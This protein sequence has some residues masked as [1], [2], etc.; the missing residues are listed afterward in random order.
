MKLKLILIFVM[1]LLIMNISY[2]YQILL[3][4]GNI[5]NDATVKELSPDTPAGE[6]TGCAVEDFAGDGEIF[7]CYLQFNATSCGADTITDVK[8]YMNRTGGSGTD[9]I[10]SHYVN[11]SDP[12]NVWNES[13]AGGITWNNQP[14]GVV[15]GAID[16][17]FCNSTADDSNSVSGNAVFKW[18]VTAGWKQGVD[19]GSDNISVVLLGT[20]VGASTDFNF[21]SKENTQFAPSLVNISCVIAAAP[22]D[23]TPPEITLINLTIEGEL[24]QLV[25]LTDRNCTGVG[26]FC[27]RTNDTTPTFFVIT[28]ENAECSVVDPPVES[29]ETKEYTKSTERTCKDGKCDLVL[30]SGTRFVQQDNTWVDVRDARSLKGIYTIKYLKNDGVHDFEIVDLN[31]TSI[32]LRVFVKD[33][34]ELGKNIP[35]KVD[36][37][38][39]TTR[40]PIFLSDRFTVTFTSDNIFA[41]NYSFGTKST[42]IILQDADTENLEDTYVREDSPTGNAGSSVGLILNTGSGNFWRIY[43]KFDITQITADSTIDNAVFYIFKNGGSSEQNLKNISVH[44]VFNH[45]WKEEIITWNNQPCGTNFNDAN[46]CNLTLEDGERSI[47]F[48]NDYWLTFSVILAVGADFDSGNNNVSFI[49]NGTNNGGGDSQ[50]SLRSKEF[51]T[52]TTERPYLN[53]TFTP[54]PPSTERKPKGNIN[55]TDIMKGNTDTICSTTGTTIH[56][57]TLPIANVTTIGLQPFIIGC[58]DS[59]GNENLTSTSGIFY[60][61]ITD[62]ESPKV[63]L[64]VPSDNAFFI[65]GTNNSE[66][67]FNASSTDNFEQTYN[68]TG[69]VNQVQEFSSI[70]ANNSEFNFSKTV[71]LGTHTWN[72]TCTDSYNNINSSQRDFTVE[73]VETANLF[74]NGQGNDRKYEFRSIANISANCT[75]TFGLTCQIEIDLDAPGYGFNFSSG[76]NFTSFLFNITV[77]RI[78]NFSSGP[79]SITLASTDIVNVTSDNKTILQRTAI[80]VTSSG[81]TTNLNITYENRIK[82][83]FGDLKSIYL[84]QNEFIES[85]TLKIAANLTYLTAGSN[86]ILSNLTDIDKPI[87]LTFRLS[88]FDLDADNEF[89]YTEFFNDTTEAIGFN[90]SLSHHTDA[91]LGVLDNFDINNSRWSLN[92]ISGSCGLNYNIPGKI[93]AS[94]SS[95]AGNNADIVYSDEAGDFRNSSKMV[96][97]F[98]LSGSCS[99]EGGSIGYELQATDGTSNVILKEFIQFVAGGGV[100]KIENIVIQKVTDTIWNVDGDN[101]D[102][103]LLD[104]DKQIT[105][106]WKSTFGGFCSGSFKLDDINWSGGWLNYSNN[107]GTYK[108]IGNLTS[109]VLNVSKTNITRATLIATVYEPEGTGPIQFYLSNTCNNTQPIFE[110]VTSGVTHTFNTIGNEICWKATLN[111]S[112]NITSPI[113]RKVTVDITPTSIENVTVENN[114]VNKFTHVGTLNSTSGLLLVNFTPVAGQLNTIKISSATAGLIQVD[115]FQMNASINPIVLNDS[116]FET[117]SQCVINLSFSGDSITVDG[118]EWDFLGSW[119]YSGV[120]RFGTLSNNLTIQVYYSNFNV[121]IPSAYPFYDVFPDTGNSKNVTPFTQTQARPIWNV[122]NQAYDENINIYVKTNE[123]VNACLNS[124]FSNNTNRIVE[125]VNESFVWV[126]GT[127]IQLANFN[128]VNNSA[129]VF[130]QT[131]GGTVINSNNYTIDYDSGTITLNSS[132]VTNTT[133]INET[134]NIILNNIGGP[135]SS[136]FEFIPLSPI[137]VRNG[138]TP[139]ALLIEN[140]DFR[141]NNANQNFTLINETYNGTTLFVTYNHSTSRSYTTG[142]QFG[143]NYSR[144]VHGFN[145]DTNYTFIL[146]ESYQL[147]LTNIS[148][149]FINHPSKG[150]WNFWDLTSCSAGIDISWFYFA[151]ICTDCVFEETQLDNFNIIIE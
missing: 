48:Q 110:T 33:I 141:I 16:P 129:V 104:F 43:I 4:E 12:L 5:T 122:S 61:N 28:N 124:T 107:N 34:K 11:M 109:K 68:C 55:H 57:C 22:V 116:E 90:K 150:I 100:S 51:T 56:T 143:I 91:P 82:R 20:E 83:F 151:S 40:R 6:Q 134:E 53:I 127:A 58:N 70:H 69:Y 67:K 64:D 80:N 50:T 75:Q 132:I 113:V 92:L 103:S 73:Q 45:T 3:T 49:L 63:D 145:Y 9:T 106:L 142:E 115:N 99:A 54:P 26:S 95:G 77:L 47:N 128:L 117:C 147:I 30:Y 149:D 101:K 37:I 41:S 38:Q 1:L 59:S 35:F 18:N 108:P 112:I 46:V 17:E 52:D 42:T 123:T 62:G 130:N 133:Q 105:L 111:S 139:F 135:N 140:V 126:N 27:G 76:D 137:T 8:L 131:D 39:K 138:T 98:D 136:F 118:L 119:N 125:V 114:G 81:T 79:S 13:G 87:N 120:A 96:T 97:S 72:V 89:S 86:F 144:L 148:V 85:G 84:E 93:T 88:G 121:S 65:L 102:I 7:R 31:Y 24:G 25:S 78:D 71:G 44:H 2:A 60:I 14:C 74:L 94:C 29:V 21:P 23:T 66:I 19:S 36:G 15:N 146:N 10:S 32:E